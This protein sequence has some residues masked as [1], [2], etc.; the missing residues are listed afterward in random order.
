MA[1]TASPD[2]ISPGI[3]YND[4]ALANSI[5]DPLLDDDQDGIS[6][7]T[8]YAMGS[9]PRSASFLTPLSINYTG[10]SILTSYPVSLTRPD[11]DLMLQS[12]P[13]LQT[14]TNVDTSP[15]LLTSGSQIRSAR[16]ST[17]DPRLFWSLKI[18]LKP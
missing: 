15:L 16:R 18:C 4:W 1:A 10:S 9:D 11:V 8:E 7:L 14:W 5:S 12:S 6:N 17:L 2:D 3:F 13:D